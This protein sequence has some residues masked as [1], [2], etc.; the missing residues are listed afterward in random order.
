MSPETSNNNLIKPRKKTRWWIYVLVIIILSIAGYSYYSYT[1]PQESLFVTEAAAKKDLRQSVDVTGTIKAADEI[2]LNFKSVGTISAVNVKVGDK[3]KKDMVLAALDNSDLNSQLKQAQANVNVAQAQLRQVKEGTRPEEIKLQ[4]TNIKNA[5]NTLDSAIKNYDL[6]KIT[7]DS[8][9]KQSQINLETSQK[10]LLDAR[11]NVDNISAQTAQN[12]KNTIDNNLNQINLII[13][14]ELG[15]ENNINEIFS[16]QNWYKKFKDMDFTLTNNCDRLRLETTTLRNTA[17]SSY[18]AAIISKSEKDNDK[19]I[20]DTQKYINNIT[21]LLQN[22]NGLVYQENSRYF[23]D[24]ND[25][26]TLKSRQTSN[27]GANTGNLT[28]VQNLS[29]SLNNTKISNQVSL[30]NAKAQITNYENQVR[31]NQENIDKINSNS[32]SQL[33]KALDQITNARDQLDIQKTQLEL[34]KSGP[35]NAAISVAEAQVAQAQAAANIIQT[36]IN[37]QSIIAPVDGVITQVNAKGGEQSNSANPIIQ[38]QSNAKYEINADIAET[39]I[40]KIKLGD[41]AIIT[42]DALSKEEDFTGT[43]VSTDPAATIIQGVVYYKTKVILDIQDPR[44]KPG[45]TANI[46][47][48]TAE[49]PN[50]LSVPNQ[51]VKT[52]DNKKTVE[53]LIDEKTNKT[54]DKEV[55]VGL[56]G[57]THTEI[58]TGLTGGEKIIILKK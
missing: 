14:S 37:N 7:I 23:F 13:N 36:Q 8:D 35:T 56:R 51:A 48:I 52:K 49:K 29:N 26:A 53:I 10:T 1:R 5:E 32:Q 18:Q 9:L 54:E 43:I 34:K 46:E 11:K 17:Q 19:A 22:L 55:T 3:V 2:K 40:D 45:M 30:D 27:E 33:Q 41:K 38:M 12:L 21:Q 58:I 4:E 6:T 42:F 25:L 16:N 28:S 31:L 57:N 50:T 24:A 20:E 15:V 39:D 47:V 44:I